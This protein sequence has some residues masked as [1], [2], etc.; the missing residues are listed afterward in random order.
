MKKIIILLLVITGL[1]VL[2]H[3][4]SPLFINETVNEDVPYTTEGEN[5]TVLIDPISTN[6]QGEMM[7]DII[8]GAD[9]EVTEPMIEMQLEMTVETRG[10]FVG[11]DARHQGEGELK[12]IKDGNQTFLRFE[13]FSVTN[14]PD[15]FVTLNKGNDPK[16]EHDIVAPLKGNMGNQNYDISSFD[17]DDYQSVSIYCRAFTTEFATA[18]L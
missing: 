11:A 10:S 2:W 17:I 15:L 14:G 7:D 18:Q 12:V 9:V 4:G 5:P 13:N 3:L 1:G 8:V 16:G 6:D